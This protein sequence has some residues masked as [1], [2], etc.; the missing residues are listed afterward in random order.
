VLGAALKA[1]SRRSASGC[2][3]DTSSVSHMGDVCSYHMSRK[4][5]DG[6]RMVGRLSFQ[7]Y[8]YTNR[9]RVES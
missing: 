7:D 9:N 8:R 5:V 4:C 2:Y 1:T 6:L 3:P